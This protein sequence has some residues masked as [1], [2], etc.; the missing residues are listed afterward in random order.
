VATATTATTAATEGI[1][2]TE[3]IPGTVVVVPHGKSAGRCARSAGSGRSRS[4][5]RP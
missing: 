2:A 5:S 4:G 1:R 3:A